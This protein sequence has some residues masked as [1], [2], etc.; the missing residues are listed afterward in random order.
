MTSQS[1]AEQVNPDTISIDISSQQ[2]LQLDSATRKP[3]RQHGRPKYL[4]EY[5]CNLIKSSACCT[6]KH[7]LDKVLNYDNLS[8][9][10]RDFVFSIVV[11][12]APQFYHVAVKSQE[13]RDAMVVEIEAI[14]NKSTWSIA[15]LHENK[16]AI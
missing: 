2:P 1:V 16:T 15:P 13:W 12:T 3:I 5:H 4:T 7:T 10:F 6:S 11:H 9:P 14:H 8:I